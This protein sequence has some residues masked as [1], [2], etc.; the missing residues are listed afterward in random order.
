MANHVFS[1][2]NITH[3]NPDEMKIL[4]GLLERPIHELA[5]Y[6]LGREITDDELDRN[7]MCDT[8]GA[9]W[10]DFEDVHVDDEEIIVMSTSAW[11]QPYEMWE[12]LETKGFT[13]D[14]D[15]EDEMPNFIGSYSTDEGDNYVDMGAVT[16]AVE[17][18]IEG[19]E[20]DSKESSDYNNK[21]YE[22]CIAS[23]Y[24]A[25]DETPTEG[26]KA[27]TEGWVERYLEFQEHY[28]GE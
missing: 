28:V 14:A 23:A 17:E 1:R 27:M 11:S 4:A 16:E 9:K 25:M 26:I 19:F 22:E 20:C 3:D 2:T 24:E 13:I 12:I 5:S 10:I 21:L 8:F 18:T 15:Y 7:I 6:M